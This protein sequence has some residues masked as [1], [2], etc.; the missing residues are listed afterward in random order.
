MPTA[1][2]RHGDGPVISHFPSGLKAT[3]MSPSTGSSATALAVADP[4]DLGAG[5]VMIAGCQPFPVRADGD[6]SAIVERPITRTQPGSPLM[7]QADL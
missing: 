2:S 4:P 3:R 5:R 1:Q 7:T 6:V